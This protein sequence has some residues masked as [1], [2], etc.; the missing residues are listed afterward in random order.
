MRK[1]SKYEGSD[2]ESATE[3]SKS[4]CNCLHDCL[5]AG[6][7]LEKHFTESNCGAY[8]AS[9]K[10][11]IYWLYHQNDRVQVY[12]YGKNILNISKELQELFPVDVKLQTRKNLDSDWAKIAPCFFNI[13]TE[14]QAIGMRQALLFLI[15]NQLKISKEKQSGSKIIW[16]QPSESVDFDAVGIFEGSR[17]SVVVNRYE[18]A[19]RNRSRCIRKFG[20]VCVVCGFDFAKAFGEIGEGY[21]HVH[22]LTPLAALEG[23]SRKIDPIKDMRPVC[24]NCHEMLHRSNPPFS[25]E[26]LKEFIARAKTR[27]SE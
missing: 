17:V 2:H 16:N 27:N 20:T 25:I 13:E 7:A 8:A 11:S 3:L 26:Q 23:K 21:I 19:P 6:Y 4:L 14:K 22:H 15:E 1:E 24:P 18:R 5:P 9:N 10:A 12:L